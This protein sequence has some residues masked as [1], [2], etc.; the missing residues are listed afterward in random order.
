MGIHPSNARYPDTVAIAYDHINNKLS[1]VY[2][3]HSLYVWDVTDVKRVSTSFFS[4]LSLG[5]IIKGK[6]LVLES[7]FQMMPP[8]NTVKFVFVSKA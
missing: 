3:D 8:S 2:N 5:K 7:D 4:S 1:A 6:G